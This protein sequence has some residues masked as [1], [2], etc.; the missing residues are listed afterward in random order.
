MR[1]RTAS[2]LPLTLALALTL[3][4]VARA[5]APT[6][7]PAIAEETARPLLL[8]AQLTAGGYLPKRAPC[9][10]PGTVCVDLDPPPFWLTANV[11]STV[12][13][14]A[15]PAALTLVT[16][17]HYGMDE[18]LG[19][20]PGLYLAR[21]ATDGN[22]FVMLR[23]AKAK[24]AKKKDGAL[25]L[26]VYA[27]GDI[28]WLPCS[29]TGLREAVSAE[30][31]AGDLAIAPGD[32][33]RYRVSAYPDLFEGTDRGVVPRYAISISRLQQHLAGL[34]AAAT[35]GTCRRPT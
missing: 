9:D 29:S 8:V 14:E 4:S 22:D 21:L 30:D 17:S 2:W 35:L 5:A 1:K 33:A 3:A 19:P 6:T 10:K 12:H 16:T 11:I 26:V 15:V 13:G 34:G 18:Y 27:P 20:A 32:L 31:F 7:F 24:L 23:Y 25:Y 28:W